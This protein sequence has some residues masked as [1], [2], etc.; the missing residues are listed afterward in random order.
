[1][2]I[3]FFACALRFKGLTGQKIIFSVFKSAWLI[4]HFMNLRY[5]FFALVDLFVS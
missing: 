3:K 1:M 4:L 5:F 2:N